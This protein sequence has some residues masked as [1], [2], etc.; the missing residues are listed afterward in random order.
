MVLWASIPGLGF[1][2]LVVLLVPFRIYAA[3]LGRKLALDAPLSENSEHDV[4]RARVLGVLIRRA[5]DLTPWTS[6]CLPQAL[7]AAFWL[8]IFSI[9][10]R[11]YLGLGRD[12]DP[13]RSLIAHAWTTVGQETITGATQHVSYAPVQ[14]FGA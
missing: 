7:V 2:R 11:L 8:R 1:A 12:N 3:G 14:V 10:Y 13:T 9:D 6:S 5:A 4:D